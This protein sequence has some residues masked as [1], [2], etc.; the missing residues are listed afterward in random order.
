MT[1]VGKDTLLFKGAIVGAPLI[2]FINALVAMA[3][4]YAVDSSSSVDTLMSWSCRWRHVPMIQEPHFGPLCQ[5]SKAG[6][7]L[8]VVLVPLQLVVVAMAAHQVVLDKRLAQKTVF[9]TLRRTDTP[10]SMMA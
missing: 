2:G 7:V 4:F 10:E 5:Q 6:L 1:Q 3:H 8:V 9:L